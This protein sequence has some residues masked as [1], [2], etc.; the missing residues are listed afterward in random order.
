MIVSWEFNPKLAPKDID[1]YSLRG[2]K[3]SELFERLGATLID[4]EIADGFKRIVPKS[5]KTKPY[6]PDPATYPPPVIADPLDPETNWNTL[7]EPINVFT[8]TS[9]ELSVK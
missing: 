6:E 8:D 2:L 7:V 4:C 1:V 3:P 5:G 9:F